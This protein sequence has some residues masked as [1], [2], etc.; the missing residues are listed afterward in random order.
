V[1]EEGPQPVEPRGIGS[2][3]EVLTP[4][5]PARLERAERLEPPRTPF[6]PGQAR[7]ARRRT[8]RRPPPALDRESTRTPGRDQ[9]GLARLERQLDQLPL[10][11]R[12][13]QVRWPQGPGFAFAIV[14]LE[15]LELPERSAARERARL[16]R[17]GLHS[18]TVAEL[19]DRD[20]TP[21][22]SES[23]FQGLQRRLHP[24]G[25]R[26]NEARDD[27]DEQCR[28]DPGPDAPVLGVR[29][30]GSRFEVRRVRSWASVRQ[31]QVEESIQV[32]A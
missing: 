8:H 14:R 4:T 22:R 9:P 7:R 10:A 17:A 6:A 23:S 2:C 5:T 12:R 11:G 15:P 28:D 18:Q 3:R 30:R 27:D 29:G 16:D 1:S 32:P 21:V 26:R 24:D 20:S 31:V 25:A 19:A 13:G